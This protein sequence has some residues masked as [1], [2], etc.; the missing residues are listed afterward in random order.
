MSTTSALQSRRVRGTVGTILGAALVFSAALPATAID[1][2]ADDDGPVATQP[3]TAGTP[4]F[5]PDLQTDIHIGDEV[6]PSDFVSS[7][8]G[9]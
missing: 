9:K 6:Q 8:D 7:P 2:P 5:T 1:R 3:R 4:T